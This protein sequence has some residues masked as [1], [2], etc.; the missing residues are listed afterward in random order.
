[1][2]ILHKGIV[3][4]Y[5]RPVAERAY[6]VQEQKDNCYDWDRHGREGAVVCRVRLGPEK[7]LNQKSKLRPLISVNQ[8]HLG[9]PTAFHPTPTPKIT[10]VWLRP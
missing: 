3:S 8:E 4:P 5:K 7:L 9:S 1:M 2:A 6:F 10:V